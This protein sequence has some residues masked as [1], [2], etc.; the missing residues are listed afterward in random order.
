VAAGTVRLVGTDEKRV[1]ENAF[2]LLT[3]ETAYKAMA[4]AVNPYGDGQA[5]GRIVDALLW[6]YGKKQEKPSVFI[7]K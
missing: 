1:Y 4:E 3:D 5:A 7:A 6:C 2:R